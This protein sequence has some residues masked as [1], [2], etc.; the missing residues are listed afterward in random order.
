MVEELKSKRVLV[1][2]AGASGMVAVKSCLDEGLQPV[3]LER[4]N[5]I[6]GMWKYS[7]KVEEGQA[8]VMKSTVINTSKEM[9]CYSDFPI[10]A[11]YANFMHNTQLYKY[12]EL[13][14]ENF[15]LKDYVK[16][17]TEVTELRQADDFDKTG[18]WAVDYKDKTS[19][20]ET[21]GEVYDAV[22]V[23]TGHHA[24]KKMPNFPGEDVF[25]GKIVHTH[26]YRSHIGYED[27]RVVVVGIGN[28][29]LDVAVE[30]SKIAKKVYLSTR[31]GSWVM[32]RVGPGGKPIDMVG[33]RRHLWALTHLVPGW[34]T[35]AVVE[36]NL[37]NR[38]DHYDY[39]LAPKHGWSSHHPA[40]NDELPNRLACG[41]VVVKS[42]VKQLHE[43]SVEFDDGTKEEDID[44][45]IYA[46]GFT[47]GFPFIKH[48]DLE[49]KDN[50]LPLYKYCFPPNMQHPTLALIGFFQP[51][52]AINPI[53]ELQC[54][55]AT[56]V[57][58]GLSKLP[59][60]ELM[61]NEIR[62]KKEN[63]AKKFYKSTRHTI[64]VEYV[65]FMDEVAEALGCKP[66][67]GQLWLSD[68]KLAY[69][70]TFGPVTPYH[71]RLHGPGAWSGA[72]NA[73]MTTWER[74]ATPNKTR[75]VPSRRDNNLFMMAVKI[76][77][78]ALLIKW[79]ID[80]LI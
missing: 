75:P 27:K 28:S 30:L 35:D 42:N 19:G 10:P 34:V 23:C 17:N 18:R 11:E 20:E 14:A 80:Y 57:F 21:K 78:V 59:S 12:F 69:E 15:K 68:P 67:I 40:V 76:I 71:Y 60:K 52:G 29:G 8:S 51:L 4:S 50:Q 39:G 64:Q 43:T 47:F 38:F 44:A 41:A 77:L 54:R 58:Q 70:V 62:E 65:P 46:T 22:L 6:G 63:M 3:C 32:N 73:I 26:D 24:E 25:K 53:S 48:P 1:I 61:L 9:M 72:R 45:V 7:D 33:Q 74:A 2:G 13:Y 79:L 5:H 56:R 49:V 37:N 36:N 55:W 16:F 31:S 66:D